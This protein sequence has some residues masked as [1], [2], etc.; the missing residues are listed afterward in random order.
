[1]TGTAR[2]DTHQHVVPPFYADW[3]AAAGIVSGGLPIPR[4]DAE[5]ALALMDDIG[6]ESAVLS[7]STPG[8]EPGAQ[9]EA[10]AMARSL[11]EFCARLR[12]RVPAR[13]GF[14]A[15]LTL[16]D[17]D[18]AVREAGHALDELGADGVILLANSRGVYLG[19]SA[20]DP[21]MEQLDR[22]SAV[23][24]VHPSTLPADPVPGL[25]PYAADFLL[26]TTRAAVNLARSGCLER[27]PNVKII[28]SHA[29]GFVPYAAERLAQHCAPQGTIE[30]GL[31][32]MRR[33]Y[34][35]TAL[36]S[37]PYALPSL[38]AFADP[39]H[40]TYGS[41]WP[42]APSTK[43]AHFARLLDEFSLPDIQRRAIDRG[44]A[45]A[46]FPRLARSTAPG[47]ARG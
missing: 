13:F 19:D 3:L 34:Y 4:W 30:D 38:L 2:I 18:G 45:E 41:D 39:T 14:F 15:T 36:S 35:D 8:V 21:L 17:V 12:D 27:Y 24:F 47:Q 31:A 5:S 32:R 9:D 22:R 40:I 25:P 20:F 42:Y 43:S 6:I 44:N 33:F 7:V 16:P 37:S 1:M 46:L 10:R 11:N 26:D 23:V 28:L 29:G